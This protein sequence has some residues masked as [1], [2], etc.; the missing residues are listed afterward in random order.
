MKSGQQISKELWGK[1]KDYLN[2]GASYYASAEDVVTVT[3]IVGALGGIGS[4][5]KIRSY[6]GKPHIIFS[7]NPELRKTLTKRVYKLTDAKV[8][9]L[10]LGRTALV[11]GIKDGGI[12]TIYLL[13]GYR[14]IDYFLT[15]NATL[16]QLVG[17]LAVDIVKIGI[18]TGASIAAAMAITGTAFAAYAI[19]PIVFVIIVGV[20]TSALLDSADSDLRISDQVVETLDHAVKSIQKNTNNVTNNINFLIEKEKEKEKTIKYIN[21]Y[22]GDIINE[23]EKSL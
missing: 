4:K 15:D 5:V 21:S 20:F 22:V 17:R 11:N 3:K 19:V 9:K 2:K 18:A 23:G 10:A 1:F 12:L 8:V 13:T 6:Q 16:T 14:V 7:G